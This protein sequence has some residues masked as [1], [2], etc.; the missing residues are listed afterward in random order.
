LNSIWESFFD[1]K[2]AE[3]NHI[4]GAI[5]NGF[6]N[7]VNESDIEKYQEKFFDNVLKVFKDRTKDYGKEFYDNLFPNGE[8]L[9]EYHGKVEGLIK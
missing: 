9:E 2:T 3:S 1:E 7:N 4:M 8:K 5:M 6:N